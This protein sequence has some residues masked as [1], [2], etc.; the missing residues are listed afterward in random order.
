MGPWF[1][2]AVNSDCSKAVVLYTR[3]WELL[4][5]HLYHF[6]ICLQGFLVPNLQILVL[7]PVLING[8]GPTLKEKEGYILVSYNRKCKSGTKGS[9][10]LGLKSVW[11]LLCKE[12]KNIFDCS[13]TTHLPKH[14]APVSI[15]HNRYAWI[16]SFSPRQLSE[17]RPTE[18]T[19]VPDHSPPPHP[20]T[21]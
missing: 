2:R 14:A 10:V 5:F 3:S 12:P 4:K 6:P 17:I 9:S 13:I 18:T 16:L 1:F 11:F 19:P 21:V 20:R 7:E 8:Y 15:G